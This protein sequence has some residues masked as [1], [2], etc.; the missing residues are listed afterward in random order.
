MIEQKN[1]E[2][3]PRTSTEETRRDEQERVSR[4]LEEKQADGFKRSL[5]AAEPWNVSIGCLLGRG[6]TATTASD[7]EEASFREGPLGVTCT[8]RSGAQVAVSGPYAREEKAARPLLMCCMNTGD[9]TCSRGIRLLRGLWDASPA[10]TFSR[11]FERVPNGLEFA[12]CSLT[13]DEWEDDNLVVTL[14]RKGPDVDDCIISQV[15]GDGP[16]NAR[17]AI[18][19]LLADAGDSLLESIADWMTAETG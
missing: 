7:G 15:S 1:Q 14:W 18:I 3:A 13:F 6:R 10:A 8:V 11:W 12:N 4:Q 17:E 19:R 5:A 2:S 9:G 16:E